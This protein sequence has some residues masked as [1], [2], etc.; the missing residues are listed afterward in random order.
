[1]TPL[2]LVCPH[3]ETSFKLN[4]T[5][6]APTG[7]V[8]RCTACATR[9]FAHEDGAEGPILGEEAH[10]EVQKEEKK[11]KPFIAENDIPL[12]PDAPE[13]KARDSKR[14]L[15]ENKT[16]A[17]APPRQMPWSVFALLAACILLLGFF[18]GRETVLRFAPQTA[19]LYRAIGL[20]TNLLGVEF[21]NITTKRI[22]DKASDIL[23]I[24]GKIY[25][26]TGKNAVIPKILLS[27]RDKSGK[28]I[29]AWSAPAP[30]EMLEAKASV[31]FRARLASPPLEGYDVLLRFAKDNE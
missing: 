10:D 15:Y 13:M 12:V 26:Y 30:Q 17:L 2:I 18:I 29:Y 1:M 14:V 21:Q 31:D 6:L 22:E 24:E 4:P 27:L 11:A 28:E 9:W 25:N 7:A 5:A 19:P 8:V 3:C 16:P 20:D 23:I